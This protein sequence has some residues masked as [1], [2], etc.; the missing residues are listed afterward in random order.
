MQRKILYILARKYLM[1]DR[2]SD[3]DF[4]SHYR[5]DSLVGFFR[6][7]GLKSAEELNKVV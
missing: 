1:K 4:K 7:L 3:A 6:K 2:L 5:V